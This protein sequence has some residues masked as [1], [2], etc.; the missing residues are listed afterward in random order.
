MKMTFNR[1]LILH[2]LGDEIESR[3]P[4][5]SASSI[6]YWLNISIGCKDG[7]VFENMRTVPNKQQIHRTLKDLL[8]AGLITGT[9]KKEEA[10]NYGNRLPQWVVYYQLA[11]DVSRNELLNECASVFNKTKRAKFGVNCF[12]TQICY[13]LSKEEVTA[14]RV[15]TKSLMQRTHPD[16]TSGYEVQFMQM[17]Q[18]A[19][20]IK[21]GIPLPNDKPPTTSAN[22][23]A[24]ITS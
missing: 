4:P 2:V 1:K 20:W 6:G 14:L 5:H 21:D 10:N 23:Q 18:C 8:R 12:G 11:S 13:G 22:K 15:Q 3:R 17:K 16:K 7:G 24:F 9:K 19:D